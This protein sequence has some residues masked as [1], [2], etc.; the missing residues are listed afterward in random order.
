MSAS[1]SLMKLC[2]FHSIIALW[3]SS[4]PVCVERPRH[5]CKVICRGVVCLGRTEAR[6]FRFR[7]PARGVATGSSLSELKSLVRACLHGPIRALLSFIAAGNSLP[8]VNVCDVSSSVSHS[9]SPSKAIE[10]ALG[11]GSRRCGIRNV[12]YSGG[13]FNV[14][15][16]L[17]HVN[18]PDFK[19][20]RAVHSVSRARFLNRQRS[21]QLW[22]CIDGGL[23]L[24]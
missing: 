3:S 19:S 9:K 13:W 8:P 11:S 23:V 18:L 20:V 4:K 1:A 12:L 21:R 5:C 17:L 15:K 6:S 16:V 10:L 14:R 24:G 7:V 2:T 22:S